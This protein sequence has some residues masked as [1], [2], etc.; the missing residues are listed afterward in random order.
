MDKSCVEK[1]KMQILRICFW[2]FF[3]I[4]IWFSSIYSIFCGLLLCWTQLACPA[5]SWW[6]TAK[7]GRL[8]SNPPCQ[9]QDAF[10][11][12]SALQYFW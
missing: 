5:V 11:Q 4:S 9:A 10:G 7:G 12:V 8:G 6:Y 2:L 3:K 1:K